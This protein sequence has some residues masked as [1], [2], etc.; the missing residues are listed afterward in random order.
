M[1]SGL[2]LSVPELKVRGIFYWRLSDQQE[3]EGRALAL[4]P[5]KQTVWPPFETEALLGPRPVLPWPW[6]PKRAP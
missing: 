5:L 1:K 4:R 3:K 6:I 2:F